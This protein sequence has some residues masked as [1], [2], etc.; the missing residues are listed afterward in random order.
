VQV[1]QPEAALVLMAPEWALEREPEPEALTLAWGSALG[2][3]LLLL[4]WRRRHRS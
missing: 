1:S 3:P 2:R 4:L